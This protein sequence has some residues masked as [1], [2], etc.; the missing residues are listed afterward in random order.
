METE[1]RSWGTSSGNALEIFLCAR[2]I[3]AAALLRSGACPHRFIKPAALW[4][5]VSGSVIS[6]QKEMNSCARF[7]FC[8]LSLVLVTVFCCC[9]RSSVRQEAAAAEAEGVRAYEIK[10]SRNDLDRV[11]QG[12]SN[13][14][15]PVTFVA[16]GK[17]YEHARLRARG[18]WSRGWP[19]KAL[20]IFFEKENQ[21]EHQ[22]CLNLNSAWRDPAFFREWLSYYVF[23]RSGAVASTSRVVRVTVNGEFHG[24]YLEVEQPDKPLL[25]RY[26]LKGAAVYKANSQQNV[27]D[28]R[29]LGAAGAFAQHYEKET[30]KQEP[31]ADLQEFCHEL[32]TT[33]NVHEFF[34]KQVDLPK[35]INYLAGT[36]LV[37]NW[38]G[39]NKNHFL[40]H[41]IKGRG[42]W[43]PLPWDLD[44]TFG[45]SWNGGFDEA[46]MPI[47]LGTLKQPGVTGWN[48]Q[49]G[50]FFSDP[51]LRQQLLARIDELLRTEFTPEK[52]FP[53]IDQLENSIRGD[54]SQDC[55]KW[56]RGGDGPAGTAPLKSFIEN[57]RGFIAKEL[58]RLRETK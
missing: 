4:R 30:R 17:A 36:I 50:R 33:R 13:E 1:A 16:D 34:E 31:A 47:D 41:D 24:L 52:L 6:G 44:R 48:R 26:G 11:E 27:A 5:N 58:V 51:A 56:R 45:D 22:R 14:T 21:F 49:E 38:D 32:A 57:R 10:V 29:D 23:A 20:K 39:F 43:F 42:K 37:Q 8:S 9:G 19:K 12:Y 7:R 53:V 2:Q 55:K 3:G 18:A 54:L 40:V 28:E 46:S 15:V 35:Y 25:E